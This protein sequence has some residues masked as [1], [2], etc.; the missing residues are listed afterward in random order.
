MKHYYPFRVGMKTQVIL[1]NRL[2]LIRVIQGNKYNN[3]L[4][5]K[6]NN[7]AEDNPTSAISQ[8][9]KKIL[10]NFCFILL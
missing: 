6:S 8:L 7:E 10:F 9:Y 4:P 3:L 2:F 1:K 5:Q